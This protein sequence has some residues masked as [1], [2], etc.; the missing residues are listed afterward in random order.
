MTFSETALGRLAGGATAIARAIATW[1]NI[2]GTLVVLGLVLVVNVDMV[3]RGAFNL[4]FRGAVEIVLFSM[5]MIVF[6]QLPDVVQ[7][8]RL[9]RSDGF[10]LVLGSTRPKLSGVIRRGIDALSSLF[11]LMVAIAI[12]PEFLD[13]WET[14]DYFGIPGVFTAP[15]WPIKLTIFASASLCTLLFV[16]KATLP[17][18]MTEVKREPE[19]VMRVSDDSA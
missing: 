8:N 10:L 4:P 9:T 12:W 13:M 2:A 7:V 19:T 16:L 17:F 11:M 14:Q 15:Y 1:A 3:G 18:D 5:V 6:L